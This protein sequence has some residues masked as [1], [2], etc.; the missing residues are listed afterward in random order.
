[1]LEIAARIRALNLKLLVIDT[2]NKFI[3]TGF[4]KELAKHAGGK[5][6]HLPKATDQAIAA[7]TQTA[8]SSLLT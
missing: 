4:A 3:S 6:H 2:E 1:L 5:Y 8:M 7:V